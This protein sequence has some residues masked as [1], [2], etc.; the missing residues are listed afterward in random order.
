MCTHCTAVY[1]RSFAS[2]ASARAALPP[3]QTSA[4]AWR[5]SELA[6]DSS[7]WTWTLCGEEIDA[8]SSAA[9]A[10]IAHGHWQSR[11]VSAPAS[12]SFPL[13]PSLQE[14]LRVLR[15]ELTRG[16]GFELVRGL[17]LHEWSKLKAAA[18]FVGLGRHI[19]GLRSQN[20]EG[21]LLGSVADIGADVTDPNTRIYQTAAR[22]TFHNDSC[23][24]VALACLQTA[25]TG[26]ESLLCSALSVWNAMLSAGRLDLAAVLLE[27]VAIDRRGEIPLGMEPYYM[28]PPLTWDQRSGLLGVGAG[29]QRR[30]IDSAARLVGAPRL[31]ALQIEA[32][33]AFDA[34]LNDPSLRL[35][36]RLERGDVQF[37]YNHTLL[38][39]RTAFLDDAAPA[40]RRQ[41]YR[42]WLAPP[43]DRLLPEAFAQRFGST[44]VGDRGG[45]VCP[46]VV[47]TLGVL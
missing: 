29:Y 9:D 5:G 36:M 33:D 19:G 15:L 12:E 10:C 31:S 40:K 41:L 34:L 35:A 13:P 47:P 24:V 23:D 8:I 11:L 45:I 28:M 22:Q 17:P 38:H 21:H 39:D 18:A 27:P 30:Y 16:R 42:L 2:V 26:G 43:E 1:R 4:A 32:L 44:A 37:V 25:R 20:K 7:R 46:G 3:L 6:T 14:R